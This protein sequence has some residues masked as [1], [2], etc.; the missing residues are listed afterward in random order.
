MRSLNGKTIGPACA[1]H[2][3]C[4][5]FC[6]CSTRLNRMSV[7]RHP[8]DTRCSTRPHVDGLMLDVFDHLHRYFIQHHPAGV[9]DIHVATNRN[10]RSLGKITSV[11]GGILLRALIVLNLHQ[12]SFVQACQLV[13]VAPRE[14]RRRCVRRT[15]F[16]PEAPV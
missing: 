15:F 14:L 9:E 5:N 4:R 8:L 16:A 1:E 10:R 13:R 7:R 11:V 3:P 12:T 2:Q 6:A